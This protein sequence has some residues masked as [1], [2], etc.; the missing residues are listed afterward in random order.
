VTVEHSPVIPT[1][2]YSGHVC[3]GDSIKLY[4]NST[5]TGVSYKWSG[6][7]N[8]T[9]QNPVITNAALFN[10]G[11][12]VL[13]TTLNGCDSKTDTLNVQVRQILLLN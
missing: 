11:K 9:N 10:S 3:E 8:S 5:E 1:A 6:L 7:I 2:S 12:Y 13:Q 4:G